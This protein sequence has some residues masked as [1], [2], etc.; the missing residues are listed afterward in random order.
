MAGLDLHADW[1][2]APRFKYSFNGAYVY[3]QNTSDNVALIDMPP[4][5]M[6]NTI[7]YTKT[8]WHSFFA[9]LRSEAVFTQTRYPDYNF[10]T[11]VPVN[12]EFA[13]VL[14][15]VSTPPSGYQLLQFTSGMQFTMGKTLASV[16]ISVNN[17]FN[18]SYRDYLNRQ[19]LYT[20]EI[21]RNFQLQIKLNY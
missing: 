13:D 10:T 7:R 4:L 14:V 11:P 19:R 6:T 16:N 1:N 2:I 5:N 15:D 3:G 9:E 17:I 12:G 21:G 18:S 8:E 20:D